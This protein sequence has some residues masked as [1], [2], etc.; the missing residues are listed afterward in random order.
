MLEKKLSIKN[1]F[2]ITGLNGIGTVIG[3]FLVSGYL[4]R[5]LGLDVLGEY[6]VLRRLVTAFL[7]V[8][9]VGMNV[10]IPILIAKN[11]NSAIGDASIFIFLFVTTPIIFLIQGLGNFYFFSYGLSFPHI[12]FV[13]GFCLLTLT[14]SLYRG[15]FN[16]LGANFL[17]LIAG[18]IVSIVASYIA[19]SLEEFLLIVGSS[20]LSISILAFI[21]RNRGLHLKRITHYEIKSLISFGLAR[22]PSF[23]FQFF[24]LGGPPLLGLSYLTLVD[25]AFLN[26]G[27]SLVRIFLI[28]VGPLGIIL[29]PRVSKVLSKGIDESLRKNLALLIQLTLFYGSITSIVLSQFS[30]NILALWLGTSTSLAG[31]TSEI[32]LFST[33]WFLLCAILRSPIDAIAHK[34]YNSLIYA[35]GVGGMIG[36]FLLMIAIDIEPILATAWAFFAGYLFSAIASYLVASKIFSLNIFSIEYIDSIIICNLTIYGIITLIPFEGNLR[37]FVSMSVFIILMSFHLL[38]SKE[39]WLVRF[40][41]ILFNN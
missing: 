4:A 22:V 6:L 40:R 14:Y 15:H 28:V 12:L 5:S 29:L 13:L 25:Q 21:R 9:L 36:T 3:I 34:G 2:I 41:G 10:T 32:L 20:M 24:M 18:T 33:P 27:I 1:D 8:L 7:G 26:A 19:S 31:K 16:M 17:Q 35:I 11:P 38:A 37:M 30:N 23:I 39:E